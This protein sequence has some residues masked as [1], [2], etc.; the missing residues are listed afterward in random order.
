MTV[1]GGPY[2]AIAATGVRTMWRRLSHL[3]AILRS[4]SHYIVR[5]AQGTRPPDRDALVVNLR[6]F[7]DGAYWRFASASISGRDL[8]GVDVRLSD[9]QLVAALAREAASRISE[10]VAAGELQAETPDQPAPVPVVAAEV[11]NQLD[12]STEPVEEDAVLVAFDLHPRGQDLPGPA[13]R[14]LQEFQRRGLGAGDMIEQW[15]FGDAIV[16]EG[17]FV[18]DD[19]VRSSLQVLFDGG[20]LIEHS[21]AFELTEAGDAAVSER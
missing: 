19:E 16:W 13:M 5:F 17:G 15:D 1:L 18:R 9:A 11:L 8:L 12:S 10:L 7:R 6:V 4:M 2:S 14:I 20:L 3:A 21:A